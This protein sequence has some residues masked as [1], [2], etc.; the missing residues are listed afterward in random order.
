[1][2]TQPNRPSPSDVA[3][4]SPE[5]LVA[6]ARA[7][8]PALRARVAQ[9]TA[10]RD[11]PAETIADFHKADLFK[12]LRSR[13]HGGF[14]GDPR[15]FFDIQNAIAEACASSA[16]VYGVLSVQ[17]LLLAT[18]DP[19]AQA[20]VFGEN[21]ETL[22]S[23]SYVPTG[24]AHAA[25]GGFRLKG[26][27]PFSSGSTHAAWALVGA[28]VPAQQPGGLPS[29]WL[30]LVPRSDYRIDANWDT[31]GLCATGSNDIIIDD[32]F[33]PMYRCVNPSPGILPE[34]E[35]PEHTSPLRRFPWLYVFTASISNLSIGITRGALKLFVDAMQT[36]VNIMGKALKDDPAIQGLAAR[37]LAEADAAEA[38]IR[39]HV[40]QMLDAIAT[41]RAVT[42]QEG[43]L[44]RAQLSSVLI[45]LAALV[46]SM[47]TAMSGR[48]IRNDA[49]LT[50]LWLD[51]MAARQHPGNDPGISTGAIG[52]MLFAAPR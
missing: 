38:V 1:M 47:Q 9:A 33:V 39:K 35:K 42:M 15:T 40:A 19:K 2:P 12:V 30:F 49:P 22:V 52:P 7:L 21:P 44:C 24:K 25:E 46:D 23:S 51:L 34:P 41:N 43:L 16:W 17:Y 50:R 45:R 29:R 4:L 10:A 27:W 6:R 18:F 3:I 36:R 37:A 32:V 20:D 26:R 14:E 8:Q 13:A 5:T 28:M 31:F 11:V 48:G